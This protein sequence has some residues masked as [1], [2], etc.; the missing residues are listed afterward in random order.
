M[1]TLTAPESNARRKGS[2]GEIPANTA[3]YPPHCNPK[4]EQSTEYECRVL[5]QDN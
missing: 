1:S 5:E 2:C 4:G 3:T